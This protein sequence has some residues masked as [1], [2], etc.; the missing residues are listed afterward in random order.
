M[1]TL[2]LFCCLFLVII[3]P[4]NAQNPDSLAVKKYYEANTI[5]WTG[6][7]KYFKGMQSYR[8]QNLKNEPIDSP[9][10]KFEFD[11]YVHSNNVFSVMI[12]ASSALI[13]SS[14]IVKDNNTKVGLLF[15]SLVSYSIAI[16]FSSKSRRHLSRFI[17]LQNRDILLR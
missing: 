16:P 13:V 11:G 12:V 9:D 3:V 8:L 17:W 5:L 10:A 2:I 14:L 7:G 1:R 15:G 6:T 4:L